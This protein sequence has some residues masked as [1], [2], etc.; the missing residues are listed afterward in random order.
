MVYVLIIFN[1]LEYMSI[2]PM[3]LGPWAHVSLIIWPPG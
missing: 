1:V 3:R 2:K